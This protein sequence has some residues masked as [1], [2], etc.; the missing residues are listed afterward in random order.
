VRDL[1]LAGPL[2]ALLALLVWVIF[3]NSAPAPAAPP[4]KVPA[5]AVPTA[6]SP[7]GP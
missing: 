5:G 3:G 7:A 6:Q 4:V 2:I 1:L